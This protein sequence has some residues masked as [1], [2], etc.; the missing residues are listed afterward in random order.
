MLKS[1]LA[2]VLILT[3]VFTNSVAE[4]IVSVPI[5]LSLDDVDQVIEENL[6]T[7]LY[8]QNPNERVC[9]PSRS[10]SMFGK[11]ITYWPAI[12]CEI[13]VLVKREGD[14]VLSGEEGRL[15]LVL[16]VSGSATL[17]GV[18]ILGKNISINSNFDSRITASI[19]PKISSDW[20]IRSQLTL[21]H[22]WL[23]P[24]VLNLLDSVELDVKQLVDPIISRVADEAA[25]HLDNLLLEMDLKAKVESAWNDIQKPIQISNDPL[26][27]LYIAPSSLAIE[28]PVLGNNLVSSVIEITGDVEVIAAEP[29][30][31]LNTPFPPLQVRSIDKEGVSAAVKAKV[32]FAVL[33]EL[34]HLSGH[35]PLE[36]SL[37]IDD[38]EIARVS[39]QSPTISRNKNGSLSV[40]VPGS[41]STED[42]EDTRIGLNMD[43]H[44][45]IDENNDRI[46]PTVTSASLQVGDDKRSDVLFDMLFGH[47][48]DLIETDLTLPYKGFINRLIEDLELHESR[49]FLLNEYLKVDTKISSVGLEKLDWT[50][51]HINLTATI[52]GSASVSTRE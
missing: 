10:F 9:I 8:V 30:V 50:D 21:I 33:S 38:I 3:F 22:E 31:R 6:P 28:N 32:P 1:R 17:Q 15:Q 51:E 18:G 7:P 52:I 47:V 5:T 13:S 25:L 11:T 12:R 14:M 49:I 2:I 37:S 40:Y 29:M 34:I 20:Q 27:Y 23:T 48:A 44:L 39:V 43:V 26:A 46:N 41:L 4:S 24:P 35:F 16:P 42:T 45:A 36:D 19:A